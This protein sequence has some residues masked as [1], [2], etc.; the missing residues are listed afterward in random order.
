MKA[1]VHERYGSPDVLEFRGVDTPVAGDGEVLVEVRAASVNAYDWHF[2]RGDPYLARVVSP[3]LGL[4][5]PKRRIRGRD[6][7]GR[8]AA[9]GAGVTRFA[10][11]DVV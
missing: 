8:V 6:F 10:P 3:Q 1:V 4:R 2:L 5:V 9:T 7:A 11:G